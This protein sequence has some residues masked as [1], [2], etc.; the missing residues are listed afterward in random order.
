MPW[1]RVNA[2]CGRAS[3]AVRL[4]TGDCFLLSGLVPFSVATDLTL[5]PLDPHISFYAARWRMLLA[6][7]K[8]TNF[9]NPISII[10]LSLGYDLE[11]AVR[12][13]V[14]YGNGEVGRICFTFL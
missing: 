13:V 6:G 14:L 5:T 9:D 2:G 11:S 4:T 1:S 3:D 12:R 7:D 8:L 10:A